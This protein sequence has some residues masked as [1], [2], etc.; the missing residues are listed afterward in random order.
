MLAHELQKRNGCEVMVKEFS[1]DPVY[2]IGV[3]ADILNMSVHS[4]RQYEREGLILTYKT[5]T[6]R[7]L[8][9][10]LE[11]E[12]IRCIKE[13]IQEQGLNF[14]GIRRLMSLIPCWKL[15]NCKK[16]IKEACYLYKDKTR[17]CWSSEQKCAH[18]LPDCRDCPVY[19]KMVHCDDIKAFIYQ[20]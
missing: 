16:E 1:S 17:P 5:S 18:P 14:E 4:L 11:L 7:R 3:A 19:Q 15:R 9:S 20:D 2:T 13:M 10:D 12:K 6:G 8:Y